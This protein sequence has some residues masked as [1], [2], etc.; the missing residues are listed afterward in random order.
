MSHVR[1]KEIREGRGLSQLKLGEMSGV[2]QSFINYI[3]AEKKQPTL[4]TLNKLASAL[5][6]PVS[7]LLD[8]SQVKVERDMR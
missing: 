4:R 3:E 6:V 2:S 8:E 5:G 7:Y 1:L